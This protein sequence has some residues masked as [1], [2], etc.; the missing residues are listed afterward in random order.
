MT[1]YEFLMNEFSKIKEDDVVTTILD[2]CNLKLQLFTDITSN[3]SCPVI[4]I[5]IVDKDTY[6]SVFDNYYFTHHNQI[7]SDDIIVCQQYVSTVR[8]I[9]LAVAKFNVIRTINK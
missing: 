7:T 8:S 6:T 2:N 9:I 3:D 1:K 5:R 4:Q